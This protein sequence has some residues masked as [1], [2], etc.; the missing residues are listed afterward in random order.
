[1]STKTQVQLVDLP[2]VRCK[3]SVFSAP[4]QL[5]SV[6]KGREVIVNYNQKIRP[7]IFEI[8]HLTFFSTDDHGIMTQT[9]RTQPG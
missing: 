2:K 4:R 1:M 8:Y 3:Q 6:V 5:I 7:V 9:D